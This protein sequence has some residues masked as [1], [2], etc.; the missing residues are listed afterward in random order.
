MSGSFCRN[1]EQFSITEVNTMQVSMRL[2]GMFIV[3]VAA[4][5]SSRAQELTP[6]VAAPSAAAP[7]VPRNVPAEPAVAVSAAP[8]A[9][10]NEEAPAAPVAAATAGGAAPAAT[11]AV[12]VQPAIPQLPE[13]VPYPAAETPPKAPQ[14]KT[15]HHDVELL[16][17]AIGAYNHSVEALR[18]GKT[19]D[20]EPVYRW[21]RRMMKAQELRYGNAADAARDHLSRMTDLEVFVKS[22]GKNTTDVNEYNFKI[23]AVQ[24]Y[25]T[26]AE[27]LFEEATAQSRRHT[28]AVLPTVSTGAAPSTTNYRPPVKV[29]P[30]SFK[31]FALKYANANA[32][33]Q[34][35]QTLNDASPQDLRIA[36]DERTNRLIMS[37]RPDFI[38]EMEALIAQLDVPAPESTGKSVPAVPPELL[39]PRQPVGPSED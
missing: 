18:T 25:R 38:E 27:K 6:A 17:R 1:T 36:V 5:F 24:Y 10:A 19:D 23:S 12:P 35:I 31:I 22:A 2:V 3:A 29:V 37:G 4:A 13:P 30:K 39:K 8:A 9:I 7:A 32:V 28:K 11:N 26:E 21:S 20:L 15:S 33:V 14:A 34:T 16:M